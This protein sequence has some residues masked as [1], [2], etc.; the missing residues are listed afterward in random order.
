[1]EVFPC[2]KAFYKNIFEKNTSFDDKWEAGNGFEPNNLYSKHSEIYQDNWYPKIKYEE[3]KIKELSESNSPI[4]LTGRIVNIYEINNQKNI[5]NTLILIYI[6][7]ETDVVEVKYWLNKRNVKEIHYNLKIDTLCTAFVT[8][9][10]IKKEDI[11]RFKKASTVPFYV[12]VSDDNEITHLSIFKNQDKIYKK[13]LKI[14]KDCIIQDLMSLSTFINGGYMA[15]SKPKVLV[16]IRKIGNIRKINTKNGYS[17]MIELR[18]FDDT[19]DAVLILW[20]NNAKSAELWTP[21]DT[22]LLLTDVSLSFRCEKAYLT[23]QKYSIVEVN[24]DMDIEWLRKYSTDISNKVSDMHKLSLEDRI[25][26]T[27]PTMA[28]YTLAE[29]DTMIRLNPKE[30]I[31]GFINVLIVKTAKLSTLRSS[32]KIFVGKCCDKVINALDNNVKCSICHQKIKLFNDSFIIGL[33]DESAQLLYPMLNLYNSSNS[34]LDD[35][36]DTILYSRILFLFGIERNDDI[37][38]VNLIKI[39]D[40]IK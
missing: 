40:N 4:A 1:M 35:F 37:W 30:P 9:T 32:N 38:K 19:Y 16:S 21:F 5:E 33:L 29:I 8:K 25:I 6:K 17:D 22:I 31:I 36:S 2:E 12:I 18:V 20:G 34:E 39:V 3:T 7:D 23:F 28:T 15:I 14:Q 27:S 11:S 10:C 26:S 13:P 24:P